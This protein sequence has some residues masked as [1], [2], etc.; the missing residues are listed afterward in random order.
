MI[1]S[2]RNRGLREFFETGNPRRLSVQNPER[3]RRILVALH[4]ATRP[5]GMNIPG[6]RFHPLRG[7]DA[8]RYAIDAS[9]NWRVT[10][11]WTD[12]GAVNVDLEDYHR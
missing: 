5:E 11:G 6:F 7:K 1:R 4:N 8:G 12:R 10:F 2:F 9:G 3:I